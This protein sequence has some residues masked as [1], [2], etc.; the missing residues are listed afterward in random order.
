MEKLTK[1]EKRIAR[2][3]GVSAQDVHFSNYNCYGAVYDLYN[4]YYDTWIVFNGS[5]TKAQR[6]RILLRRLIE[7]IGI[8]EK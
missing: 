1:Q 7:Q 3:L 5:Y 6:Y 8:T 4:D 2:A